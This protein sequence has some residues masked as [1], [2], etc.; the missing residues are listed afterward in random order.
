MNIYKSIYLIFAFWLLNLT[1]FAQTSLVEPNNEA[2]LS[3]SSI[4]FR[5]NNNNGTF[6]IQISTDSNFISS[7]EETNIINNYFKI[8][9]FSIYST[10]YWRV[11]G[12]ETNWSIKRCFTFFKVNMINSLN[13]W[14][15]PD[16]TDTTSLYVNTWY[17]V[18]GNN[19]N[20][21]QTNMDYGPAYK[22]DNIFNS[23]FLQFDGENDF[24]DIS[25]TIPIGT[26]IILG[27]YARNNNYFLYDNE[28][29]LNAGTTASDFLFLPKINTT[30]LKSNFYFGDNFYINGNK[31]ISLDPIN[32]LKIMIGI[33]N[34][35]V[36]NLSDIT[37]GT[38]MNIEYAK[39]DLYEIIIY[40]QALNDSLRTLVE[41]YLRYKYAPP[42]NLGYDINIDYG[43][44]DT[45]INAGD[46]YIDYVWSTGETGQVSS[47]TVNAGVYSVTVTDIF[48]FESSDSIKVIYPS[49][50][51]INDTLICYGDTIFWNTELSKDYDFLWSDSS[52]DSLISIFSAGEYFI[53]VTDSL[54]CYIFSDTIAVTID[55]FPVIASLG[56]DTT[57]CEGAT[58]GLISGGDEAVSYLWNDNSTDSLLTIL[59]E[60]YYSLLASNVNGC[61]YFDSLYVT[62]Q[63]LSPTSDFIANTVCLGDSTIFTDLSSIEEPYN[64]ISWEW[65]F[66]DGTTDTLQNPKHLYNEPDTFNVHLITTTDSGCVGEI[67]K[68]II[69]KNIPTAFFNAEFGNTFCVDNPVNFIDSS[70]ATDSII[71]WYWDFDDGNDTTIQNPQHIYIS[72]GTYN[73]S[74]TAETNIGCNSLFFHTIEVVASLPT[75]EYFTLI[76][77]ENNL[78]TA[79]NPITFS[80]N[81]SAGA[82]FYKLQIATDSSLNNIV[83]EKE[84]ILSNSYNISGLDAGKTYY[85]RVYAYNICC[86]SIS[87]N[88]YSVITF[89]PAIVDG[90]ELWFIPDSIDTAFSYVNTWY[91]ISGNNS[92]AIQSDTNNQP[93]YLYD[94][95]F[96]SYYLSFDGTN[97]YFDIL[98]S[99]EIG[100]AIII[101]KY[102]RNNTVF[103]FDNEAPLNSG[104][105]SQ[106]FLFLPRIN[107]TNLKD[108]FYFEDNFYINSINTVSL[109]P[110]SDLKMIIGVRNGI[111]SYLKNITI[112]TWMNIEYAKFDLFEIIIY[113]Q[114]LNDS[115]RILVEQYLYHKYAP[116]VNLG[117]DINVSY[118]FTDTTIT[119]NNYYT[120]YLW[121][122][123]DTTQSL[124]I[125]K[126]GVYSVTVT[127]IFGFISSD[128][129]K[130]TYPEINTIYDTIICYGDTITWDVGLKN[131]YEYIWQNL[132]TNSS[133]QIYEEGDYYVSIIDSLGYPFY[134]DTVFVKVDSF[135]V[136]A[137]LGSDTSLCVGNKLYLSSGSESA[138]DYLW[139]D[140]STED[141]CLI[142]SSGDYFVTVIN[143]NGCLAMDTV[144]VNVLG[145][146]PLPGFI[147]ENVCIGDVTI[148]TDTSKTTDGSSIVSWYWDFGFDNSLAQNTEIL[149][150]DTGTYSVTLHVYTDAQCSDHI[151]KNITIQPL[152][153]LNFTPEMGCAENE[154]SFNDLS[155]VT[156]SSIYSRQWD[157]GNGNTSDEISPVTIFDT[158]GEYVIS[159]K[160][161]SGYGCSDSLS[162]SILIKP[163]PLPDFEYSP[164]CEGEII[165]FTNKTETFLG[166]PVKYE[167][168]FG[169]DSESTVNN[170]E[171]IY[172][173]TGVYEI[174]LVAFQLSN[175]C[176]N[177][178]SKPIT[179]FKKPNANF[180]NLDGCINKT[181]YLIDSS[182]SL[183]GE[184]S[185][186]EW[187]IE[188]AGV[189]NVQ[190][191]QL[192][193][194]DTGNYLASLIITTSTGCKD[195]IN[196]IIKIHELPEVNFD[197]YPEFG[198]VPLT[199]TF[200]NQSIGSANFVWDFGDDN[201]STLINPVHTYQDSGY[202][203]VSLYAISEYGCEDSTTKN[204]KV[205]IPFVDL[206]I[207][208]IYATIIDNYLNVSVDFANL[209]T[210]SI[211]SID[212]NIKTEN[213]IRFSEFWIGELNSGEII[214]H[215]F[216][217]RHEFLPNNTPSYV[218][219]KAN[220]ADNM[221]DEIPDNN[222]KC[223]TFADEFI[224]MPP[225]PNPGSSIINIEFILPYE[226]FVEIN[227]FNSLGNKVK[228]IFSGELD[229]GF[230]KIVY[231]ITGLGYG[232]FTYQ[233]IF[234]DNTVSK[235]FLIIK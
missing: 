11:K 146:A 38:R 109:A 92:N 192:V 212:F 218:C 145:M 101:G 193:F 153:V 95:M 184:I 55:L 174:N 4:T 217:T 223:Y 40:S 175:G 170:P 228:T 54:G 79:D 59:S 160:V 124:T 125:N 45:E 94:N 149:Y 62:L 163:S 141:Y 93:I 199:V 232:I 177:S 90:L 39:Y 181:L 106:E 142:N 167:W 136:M 87:S 81:N 57:L 77:P 119:I 43:F 30:Y 73:V 162:K 154:I 114:S 115:L 32:N 100:T 151:T 134:S 127:D 51:M 231:N 180:G 102:A 111:I 227:L 105:T 23:Y 148:F 37:I 155:Y 147:Y 233:I 150:N 172:D 12:S 19:Y 22:F 25:D 183:D 138:V 65:D 113:N 201:Q 86:D 16:S 123:G 82:Y 103:T 14:L 195:T 63:G 206:A 166:L 31:T 188:S 137:S 21:I 104:N 213:G 9:T 208:D 131:D 58:I 191:P 88:I 194:Q 209:G 83:T 221:I 116:P 35:L 110:I 197:F 189:Y 96:N 130:V 28:S 15:I 190:N 34:D 222:E 42:V 219:V 20:A 133:L 91:D 229:E 5:W 68:Q 215:T 18:S 173:S 139:S 203:Y 47:T 120:D 211:D 50:N 99:I 214:R 24:L 67:Y 1:S 7:N 187:N 48:G 53:K 156:G 143:N 26:A 118:G 97:D 122:T 6:T 185:E 171:K 157:F 205:I 161:V 178:I 84:N 29:P 176:S 41:Q 49:V 69:V 112:C 225:Y 56:N 121:N 196:K 10:Y 230:N 179:I 78:V 70:Y 36:N 72:A 224:V 46:G 129:I 220:I 132:E 60:G 8:D 210:L 33:R 234:D 128:S 164:G 2:V 126:P 198:T 13:L 44:C 108:N 74:L 135:A 27:K 61:V 216:A 207:L 64:I 71:S 52:T 98:D 85:W 152:P 140:E 202:F 3:N 182:Y 226:N 107:T 200:E 169:D 89:N 80:W 168:D 75:P 158:T 159:L 165:Y 144:V 66:G 186:W 17:D 117:A 76:E 204:L 235:R